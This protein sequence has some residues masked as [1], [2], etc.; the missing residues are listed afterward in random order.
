MKVRQLLGLLKKDAWS[1]D[2]TRRK[3]SP[4][5]P[6]KQS[7]NGD[8]SGAFADDVHPKTLKGV[9]SKRAWRIHEGIHGDL[10]A[11]HAK[12]VRVRTGFAELHATAKTQRQLERRIRDAIA[13]HI[14]GLRLYGEPV[15][16]P[17]VKAGVVA[18]P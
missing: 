7:G 10:R 16:K 9:L 17:T 2:R 12:L 14:E 6:P 4:T 8:C 11:R 3:S 1:I 15:P 18:V 5:A 13:F